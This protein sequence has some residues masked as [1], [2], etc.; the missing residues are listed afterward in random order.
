MTLMDTPVSYRA[1]T[2]KLL[3][4]TLYKIT[5]PELASSTVTSL[6][7]TSSQS[8]SLR[9]RFPSSCSACSTELVD[10]G[11]LDTLPHLL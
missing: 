7:P 10:S 9:L 5:L 1:S 11:A 6:I 8:L 3:T 4:L 2:C